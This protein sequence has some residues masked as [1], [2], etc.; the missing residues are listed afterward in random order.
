M[1]TFRLAVIALVL[2]TLSLAIPAAAEEQVAR[3]EVGEPKFGLIGP[4]ATN[5]CGSP[6]PDCIFVVYT[7]EE[8]DAKLAADAKALKAL[9]D[10]V[11]VLQKNIKAL[12]DANDALTQ[13]LEDGEKRPAGKQ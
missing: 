5:H 9:Q 4:G 11:A 1:R 13:R 3:L 2:T 10:L 12:S 8:I 6:G 7:K